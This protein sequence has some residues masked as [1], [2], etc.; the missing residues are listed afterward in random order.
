M[1]PL[2][3]TTTKNVLN[4]CYQSINDRN[5]FKITSNMAQ[6]T[7]IVSDFWINKG[8]QLKEKAPETD[9]LS[10]IHTA[11]LELLQVTISSKR[12]LDPFT[13]TVLESHFATLRG[14]DHCKSPKLVLQ[15]VFVDLFRHPFPSSLSVT[16]WT[17][18][19]NISEKYTN[20]GD[21]LPSVSHLQVMHWLL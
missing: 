15:M 20:R 8:I 10:L 11:V 9:P 13:S 21:L 5:N 18:S 1:I 19:I 12:K 16:T 2:A 6:K 7:L 4:I 17:F 3:R 14:R